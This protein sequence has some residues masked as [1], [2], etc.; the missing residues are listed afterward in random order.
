MLQVVQLKLKGSD[1]KFH[2]L[3]PA[4]CSP[5]EWKALK[6]KPMAEVL[7]FHHFAVFDPENPGSYTDHPDLKELAERMNAAKEELSD[8]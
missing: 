6:E 7:D 1:K 4:M 5:E 8:A 3:G 2:F